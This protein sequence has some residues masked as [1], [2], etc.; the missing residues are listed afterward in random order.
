[1][2][3]TKSTSE[4]TFH[5]IITRI[6]KHSPEMVLLMPDGRY[7]NVYLPCQDRISYVSEVVEYCNAFKIGVDIDDVKQRVTKYTVYVNPCEFEK[8]ITLCITGEVYIAQ[9]LKDVWQ[10]TVPS[11]SIAPP[12]QRRASKSK[13]V[14]QEWTTKL[15]PHQVRSVEWMKQH[16][17]K[18]NKQTALEFN[19]GI[20]IP[21]TDWFFDYNMS[22]FSLNVNKGLALAK[23]GILADGA[24]M[25]KTASMLRLILDSK[26]TPFESHI[27]SEYES[28]ATLVI[29]PINLPAQWLNE[30]EKFLGQSMDVIALFTGNH[31]KEITMEDILKAD[32]VITTLAFIRSSKP[33]HDMIESSIC[34]T[35][36]YAEDKKLHLSFPAVRAWARSPG[37]LTPILHAVMWKRV[38]VD[39][40]HEVLDQKDFKIL[41]AFQCHLFWGM[42]ATPDIFSEKAHN[43]L[44]FLQGTHAQ[45]PGLLQLLVNTCIKGTASTSNYVSQMFRVDAGDVRERMGGL[46]ME[47]VVKF[48]M[49]V[50][51]EYCNDGVSV[52]SHHG[53]QRMLTNNQMQN[54]VSRLFC[55]SHTCCICLEKTCSTITNCG[56]V[57]C[58]KCITNHIQRNNN[59]CPLCRTL[60]IKSGIV[61][62]V[63]DKVATKIEALAQFIVELNSP[64]IVFAQYRTML[65]S[66]REILANTRLQVVCLEGNTYRRTRLL[67][68][69]TSNGGILLICMQDSYAGLHLPCARHII[70]SH[71]LLGDKQAVMDMEEQAIARAVRPGQKHQVQVHSFVIGDSPE[72]DLWVST[73]DELIA[74]VVDSK[75]QP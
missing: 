15:L 40:I 27:H 37:R 56:H 55:E 28:Q 44:C 17:H 24:G 8:Q 57:Y 52:C 41:T 74:T 59:A 12:P 19:Q 9:F 49:S 66:L 61:S 33:Y 47:E 53:I 11:L 10:Y 65:K 2:F 7:V 25:G 26:D 46:S 68:M 4:K 18:I 6:S 73:H 5:G 64:T 23:G 14:T 54:S 30:I 72:E 21:H 29:V 1:M 50:V 35:M 22:T 43:L 63:Q 38:I 58:H 36:G 34:S 60:L 31:I 67:G 51:E 16:E 69:F 3:S 39:E 71:A 70:F 32:I 45:H 13:G 42:T 48:G 20:R 75:N 62:V